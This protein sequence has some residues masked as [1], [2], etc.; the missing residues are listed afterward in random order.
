MPV[1]EKGKAYSISDIIREKGLPVYIQ[2]AGWTP[3]FFV[4]LDRIENNSATGDGINQ[5]GRVKKYEFPCEKKVFYREQSEAE[6]AI[7]ENAEQ[8]EKDIYDH[9]KENFSI[10]D[11]A[12]CNYHY[13]RDEKTPNY[14]LGKTIL[15]VKRGGELVDAVFT[16]YEIRNDRILVYTYYDETNKF[17]LLENTTLKY[18]DGTNAQE[19]EIR[20]LIKEVENCTEDRDLILQYLRDVR[21]VKYLVHFTPVEN[22]YSIMCEGL[23]PRNMLAT[24]NNVIFTDDV[25]YDR[26]LE[27]SCFSLS[28]PNYQMLYKKRHA[29]KETTIAI[30]LIDINVI[31]S[32]D[33]N[34]IYFL[35]VNAASQE[36][37]RYQR[38]FS[39]LQDAKNMFTENLTYK[40]QDYS[41]NVLDIPEHF[42]TSPQAEVLID[43]II[44]PSYIREIHFPQNY[45]SNKNEF[46]LF[47]PPHISCKI[48]DE[49][50]KPRKDCE[51]WS[52]EDNANG[53][54]TNFQ[55]L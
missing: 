50:F 40:N 33:I 19:P 30:L 36:F 38:G 20:D 42:T 27:C 5:T 23:L 28:F 31:I 35:P 44:S 12:P 6:E 47:I 14:I 43:G 26:C 13:Y 39:H 15:T 53:D 7:K 41:R 11:L 3:D 37:G 16:G 9:W 10:T 2:A 46:P 17:C 51:Y 8:F 29:K 32:S 52:K 55:N 1:L 22:L 18:P 21:H 48:S 34:H 24:K 49:F 25:R 54:E 4:C 45:Q